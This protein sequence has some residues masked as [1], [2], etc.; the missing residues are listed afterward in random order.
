MPSIY[1]L[2]EVLAFSK[3]AAT[4][5]TKGFYIRPIPYHRLYA[6]CCL[7]TWNPKTLGAWRS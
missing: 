5:E 1:I 3:V 2:K 7:A 6:E 4:R